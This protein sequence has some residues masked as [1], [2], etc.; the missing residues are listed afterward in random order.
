MDRPWPHTSQNRAKSNENRAV[1][2]FWVS[3]GK[4]RTWRPRPLAVGSKKG[5]SGE[6]GKRGT[7]EHTQRPAHMGAG[8]MHRRKKDDADQAV[9]RHGVASG[10][11]VG[12]QTGESSERSCCPSFLPA[13]RKP[14]NVE[15]GRICRSRGTCFRH[16]CYCPLRSEPRSLVGPGEG[17]AGADNRPA[18]KSSRKPTCGDALRRVFRR[19]TRA[20]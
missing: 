15:T 16:S 20:A 9:C 11:G 13:D 17:C 3:H 4:V 1:P 12:C 18:E 6:T 19:L 14:N 5:A 2:W 8:E 7:C 10:R